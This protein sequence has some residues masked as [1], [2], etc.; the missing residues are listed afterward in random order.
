M[1]R[2]L[3]ENPQQALTESL[4]A[5]KLAPSQLAIQGQKATLTLEPV[6]FAALFQW[7]VALNRASGIQLESITL[8]PLA[9]NDNALKVEMTL[10]WGKG[11]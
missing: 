9:K 1:R 6:A 2:A 7:Y 3:V 8:T 11:S 5:N 4:K 10:F